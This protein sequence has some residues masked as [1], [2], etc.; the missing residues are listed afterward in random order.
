ML[1]QIV[2]DGLN[3]ALS[4]EQIQKFDI[5]YN[6]LVTYNEQT[7]LT[8]ITTRDD[9]D[10]KHFYDSL[11]LAKTID[12]KDV[13]S[14]CDMGSGAGFPSI[15][16]KLIYPHLEITIIDSLGKRIMF[17]KRLIEKL[18]LHN[19]DI[20]YNRIEKHAEEHQKMFD[21]VT[22]R[23]LGNLSLILEMGVPMLKVSGEFIAYKGR[24]YE[25]ELFD[26]KNAI[27]Q[28]GVKLE[29]VS[30]YVLPFDMGNHVHLVFL[31]NQHITGYPR[32]FATMKK[33]PL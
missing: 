17:L 20:V 8:R 19:V 25:T 28:L 12:L 2:L 21:V 13:N 14:M 31:K 29:K 32:T 23:A 30:E 6:E 7:N 16:L 33:N 5:Y 3:I 26:G 9:V 10:I 4:D 1:K 15:P 18:D 22:A 27:K 11:T 24:H